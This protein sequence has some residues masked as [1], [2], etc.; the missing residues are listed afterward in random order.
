MVQAGASGSG[1]V[2]PTRESKSTT[3]AA[4]E[5]TSKRVLTVGGVTF[6]AVKGG[7]SKCPTKCTEFGHKNEQARKNAWCCKSHAA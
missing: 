7:N 5:D 6:G 4:S 2:K 1:V 3:R